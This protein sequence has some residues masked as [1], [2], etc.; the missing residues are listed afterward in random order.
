MAWSSIKGLGPKGKIFCVCVTLYFLRNV[1][2]GALSIRKK[3]TKSFQA[4]RNLAAF[5][6]F[7]YFQWRQKSIK[8]SLRE[9]F[10]FMILYTYICFFGR[11]EKKINGKLRPFRPRKSLLCDF[12]L[13]KKKVFFPTHAH[14]T[15]RFFVMLLLSSSDHQYNYDQCFATDF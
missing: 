14:S 15:W 10:L 1:S 6:H 7:H 4:N 11:R 3:W 8:I 2:P 9:K 12:L 13:R 5:L